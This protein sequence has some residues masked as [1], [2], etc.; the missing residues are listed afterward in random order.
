MYL[1]QHWGIVDLGNG[2]VPIWQYAHQAVIRTNSEFPLITSHTM[3][4]NTES[5]L[6]FLYG[7]RS[8]PAV[9]QKAVELNHSLIPCST[10][11]YGIL[12]TKM[13]MKLC[14]RGLLWYNATMILVPGGF[15]WVNVL[16]SDLNG[17]HFAYDI[18]QCIFLR[19]FYS[20]IQI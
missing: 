5:E 14:S 6:S 18:F 4:F 2:L 11:Q 20:L 3:I 8:M 10:I 7:P 1:L 9:P 12:S 19:K 13:Q 15:N 16:R 17:W